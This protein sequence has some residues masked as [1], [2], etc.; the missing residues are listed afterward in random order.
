M[1]YTNNG[2]LV[3]LMGPSGAG[4]DAFLSAVRPLA[5]QEDPDL[6]PMVIA[7]RHITRPATATSYDEQHYPCTEEE[8]LEGLAQGDY[9]MYWQSHGLYYGITQE[10][11]SGLGS[12]AVVI[13]NGSREYL[14]E[15]QKLYPDLIPILLE[16]KPE[17]LRARLEARGRESQ[18]EIEERLESA[19]TSIPA[20]KN[21]HIIDNSETL[22]ESLEEFIKIINSLRCL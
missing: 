21:L 16:V 19:G 4:K 8:F 1:P 15:A 9:V 5:E 18:E 22:Q 11:E 17:K 13:V 6:R 20:A 12:D 10:I 7:Q 2:K 14:P 3:Y